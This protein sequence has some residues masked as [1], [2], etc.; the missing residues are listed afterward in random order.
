MNK[1][2]KNTAALVLSAITIS[3]FAQN[4]AREFGGFQS[5]ESV[6]AYK[7]HLF[8]SNMGA[9]NDPSQKDGDGFISMVNRN[10]GTM[11]EEKF[12]TGLNSPKGMLVGHGY[13]LVADVDKVLV[14]RIKDKKKVWETDLSSQGIT[15]ANDIAVRGWMSA[16][17][18]STD[19]NA[20]YI[21]KGKGK[22]RVKKLEVKSSLEGANGII[23]KCGKLY[24]ANYGRGTTPN[25]S[26]GKVSLCSKKYK[27]FNSGGVYDG[28][29]PLCGKLLI[30]DWRNT[31]DG[32]GRLI[33]YKKCKKEEVAI[34]IGRD[35][36]G[37]SDLFVD[38]KYKAVWVPAMNENKLIMVQL[39]E[40]KQQ[41]KK[42]KGVSLKPTKA[43]KA[44]KAKK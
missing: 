37:P 2:I 22:E 15:Y 7:K 39:K 31:T 19:K 40:I 13:I 12:I 6:G 3:T 21:A 30:T 27:V 38:R 32:K 18:T 24:I 41:A 23:K 36:N 14:Y 11:A 26:Y 29:A 28:I 34:N 20:V 25:G 33:V 17:V 43:D 8:V 5:P 10:S 9:N 4:T 35:I 42:N 44:K 1:I 16:F